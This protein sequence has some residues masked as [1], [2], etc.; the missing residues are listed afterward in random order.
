MARDR[1]WARKWADRDVAWPIDPVEFLGNK[2]LDTSR[3]SDE[4]WKQGGARSGQGSCK[5]ASETGPGSRVP[6]R[7][8]HYAMISPIGGRYW[9]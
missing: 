3:R 6:A 8:R 9:D 2:R 7:H 4:V 1:G 5:I